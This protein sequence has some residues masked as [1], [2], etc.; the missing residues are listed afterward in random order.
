MF[1]GIIALIEILVL[2]VK[3]LM[4]SANVSLEEEGEKVEG[5]WVWIV[6]AF[7]MAIAVAIFF[8]TPLFV[9][10]SFNIDSTL[11][12]H[13]VEGL[14]R[15]AIFIVYLK[16]ISLMPDIRRVFAY[17]GAEHKTVNAYEAGVPLEVAAVKEHG[18]AHVRCGSSF[19][20]MVL[21]IAIIVFSLIGQQALWL[22]VLSRIL[23]VPIIAMLG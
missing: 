17:H 16:L 22:M 6:M 20:F 18:K 11:L 15:L 14:I 23:L 3:T 4:Y 9:T 5:W 8:V 21:V 19:M 2:G 7:S 1:R 12:F 10:R 13:L